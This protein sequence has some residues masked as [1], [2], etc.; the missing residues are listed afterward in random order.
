MP[1]GKCNQLATVRNNRYTPM[2]TK[3]ILTNQPK[4]QIKT[5]ARLKALID[6]QI[7]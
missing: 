1:I 3:H 6:L 5:L 4:A 2:L 7:N